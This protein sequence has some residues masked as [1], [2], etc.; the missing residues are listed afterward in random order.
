MRNLIH[1]AIASLIWLAITISAAASQ[2]TAQLEFATP[3]EAATTFL[4]ALKTNDLDKLREIFGPG[5][6]SVLSSGDPTQDKHDREVAL[7]AMEQKWLWLSISSRASAKQLLLGIDAWPF[8]IPLVKKG[9]GWR[10]DTAAG[11]REV[12]ARRI[13]RNELAVIKICQAYVRA[14]IAYA[15][16]GHDG[17]PA[18]MYAQKIRSEA[19][20]QDGLYWSV[21]DGE[22]RSPL[23][24][25]AAQA[26]SEG[27]DREKEPLKPFHGYF[28]R[29]L[30]A[31]GPAA[32]GGARNY[33][34]EGNMFGGFAAV[35]Y[36]AE[37][38]NS[39]VMTFIVNQDGI[40]FEK[41][42]GK[43]TAKLAGEM[44]E[45]NPDKSWRKT[46]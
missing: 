20:R 45:Y 27:Y 16:Q 12:L 11:E 35:A 44:K 37:Y 5:A 19:G 33:I 7:V 31:Q 21:K 42:L 1:R 10:F 23:G 34:V 38:K 41:D 36:P 6:A 17:K 3:N 4:Q 40:V 22:Q 24:D 32:R 14:Q 15:S 9:R 43:E 2:A 25:L 39:G 29:L 28:F 13:G 26:A 18:G 30:T 46:N 8:P